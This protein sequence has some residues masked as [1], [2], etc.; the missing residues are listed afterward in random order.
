MSNPSSATVMEQSRSRFGALCEQHDLLAAAVA[1][2]ARSLS[3]GE[4]IGE[5]D[6]K[7]FPIVVGKERV[8]AATVL[9]T[10]GHAFTDS[11][12]RFSGTVEDVLKLELNNSANRAVYT[13]TLNAVLG[14]LKMVGATV[15]CRDNEPETCALEIANTVF[16]AHGSV[17]IGLI[18][19]NPAIAERLVERFGPDRV[20]ITDLNPDNVGQPR[21]GVEIRDGLAHTEKLIDDSDVVLFTGTT[22]VNG[23]FDA[24]WNRIRS[25]RKPYLVYGVTA[26]GV[27]EL[28]KIPRICPLGHNS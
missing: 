26:A 11:P 22:L 7:D 3:P 6:R 14:R 21:F 16:E 25:M 15:H 19:F 24:I 20:A 5:P 9:E 12:R 4:A 2:T 17:H 28:L 8:I 1:V 10:T 27:C 23:T 13:A 18:G